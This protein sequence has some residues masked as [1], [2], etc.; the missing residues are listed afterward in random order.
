MKNMNIKSGSVS[1]IGSGVIIPF[2]ENETVI[3][4]QLPDLSHKVYDL[5]II[6]Q[7]LEDSDREPSFELIDPLQGVDLDE[8]DRMLNYSVIV[9]NCD[10]SN[11]VS[12]EEPILLEDFSGLHLYLNFIA[13]NEGDQGKKEIYYT[14]YTS[15][16]G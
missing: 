1:I 16:A 15:A 11:T 12:N 10:Q 13:K 14:L 2:D 5:E 7:F 8:I 3:S 4:F 6:F 9:Y